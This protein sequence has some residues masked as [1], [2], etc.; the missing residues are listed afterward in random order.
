MHT[1][2]VV[3][4]AAGASRRFGSN[5]LL[6]HIEAGV[7]VLD[8][9]YHAASILHATPL[10]V[11]SD[12]PALRA[13]C[14]ERSYPYVINAQAEQGM[15]GSIVCG[16]RATA[17]AGGWAI[18]LADMPCIRQQTMVQLRETWDGERILLPRYQQQAGHPVIFPRAYFAQLTALKGDQGARRIVQYSDAVMYLDVEDPGVLLDIDTPA[19]LQQAVHLSGDG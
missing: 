18:C 19:D 9:S 16:V 10:L 15:A 17:G 7:S 1:L 2:Q 11:I 14:E 4:L 5:K 3:L 8:R 12:D 6:H 13:H